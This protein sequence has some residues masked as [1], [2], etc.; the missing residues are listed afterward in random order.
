[1]VHMHYC[2]I[3]SGIIACMH[4]NH[5]T[6]PN[7]KNLKKITFAAA[8]LVAFFVSSCG[9]D[10]ST[11]KA[12][13]V[14]LVKTPEAVVAN[15][16]SSKGVYKGVIIGSTGT[17]K[18]DIANN[19]T[20]ITATL[21]I[22]GVTANL[23][24]TTP[25]VAGSKFVGKFTGTLGSTSVELTFSVDADGKNPAISLISI[26]GHPN[27]VV[28]VNKETSTSLIEAFTGTY[29]NTKPE[30][31]TFNMIIN[32]TEGT[33][34]VVARVDG[35]TEYHIESGTIVNGKLLDSQKKIIATLGTDTIDGTFTGGQNN[36][37]VTTVKGTRSL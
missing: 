23:T 34:S 4:I 18:F 11:T 13:D 27:A 17:V 5:C 19:G 8:L 30:K 16:S 10:D 37:E 29:S 2:S 6:N 21:V 7:M 15:N 22:D 24:S 9:K 26:P 3:E 25:V 36:T 14:V 1:M 12:P 20:T 33:W 35:G 28:V 32:R 31:G